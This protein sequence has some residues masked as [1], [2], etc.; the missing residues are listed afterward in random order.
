[1]KFTAEQPQTPKAMNEQD[2]IIA[3]LCKIVESQ[4]AKIRGYN[5]VFKTYE[6]QNDW[7]FRY[8]ERLNKDCE[9][10][11]NDCERYR[12]EIRHLKGL[13]PITPPSTP[14]HLRILD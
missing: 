14:S 3:E 2:L 12:N 6:K 4:A 10:Y 13:P 8:N 7:L 5:E 1:M 11:K 9:R